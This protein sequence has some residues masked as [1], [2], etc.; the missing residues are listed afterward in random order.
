[1][2][3]INR[4]RRLS[5]DD[6]AVLFVDH[7]TGLTTLVQDYSPSD[8]RNSVLA[9][10]DTAKFFN[11]PTVLTTSAED[12]PNGP[13]LPEL[14]EMF[15]DA[16]YVARPGEINA[17]DNKD[18]VKAVKATGRKQLLIAGIVTE[19]RRFSGVSGRGGRV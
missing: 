16:A 15:P 12:G 14:K 1:M 8:F 5:K 10:A 9:L 13:I 17:W 19:V 11:L 6:A 3:D 2:A 7:Q 4:Y 18:F